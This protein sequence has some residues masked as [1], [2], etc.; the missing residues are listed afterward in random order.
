VVV[1]PSSA[2]SSYPSTHQLRLCTQKI[3]F[4]V[5][6]NLTSNTP[7]KVLIAKKGTHILPLKY[8]SVAVS[9]MFFNSSRG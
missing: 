3:F 4:A 9:F 5:Q 6:L 7:L 2:P 1:E 8:E